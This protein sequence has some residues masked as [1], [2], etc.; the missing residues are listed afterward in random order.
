MTR[1]DS[2]LELKNR[3]CS[4]ITGQDQAGSDLQRDNL[5]GGL[6]GAPGLFDGAGVRGRIPENIPG[7]SAAPETGSFQSRPSDAGATERGGATRPW[8]DEFRIG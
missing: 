7:I 2:V 4:S 3:I 5:N 6:V 1:R 8:L